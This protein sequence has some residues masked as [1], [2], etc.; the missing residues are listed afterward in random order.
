M[1][2][3]CK[4]VKL[5]DRD[6]IKLARLLIDKY[7]SQK[8]KIGGGYSSNQYYFALECDGFITAVAWLH[9]SKPFRFI[10]QK[11]RIPLDRSLF[12]RRV[13]K[14]CPG[15]YTVLF[16]KMLSEKLRNDGWEVIWTMGFPDHSNALYEKSGFEYQ[17]KTPKTK[18]PVYAIFLQEKSEVNYNS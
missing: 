2:Q 13:T 6:D 11:F 8:L 15:D 10:A 9:D 4:I 16:L 12:I 14:T 7:H 1:S 3:E 18:H 17:G 5:E